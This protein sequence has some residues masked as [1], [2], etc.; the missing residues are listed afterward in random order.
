MS[1][2]DP[3]GPGANG[4]GELPGKLLL[5]ALF[6]WLGYRWRPR[7]LVWPT[8]ALVAVLGWQIAGWYFNAHV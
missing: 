3:E 1:V 6:G 5:V 7:A 8:L 2:R 4:L